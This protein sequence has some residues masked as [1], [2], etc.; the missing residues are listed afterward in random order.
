MPKY[1]GLEKV[2]FLAY[3]VLPA[4]FIPIWQGSGK[5]VREGMRVG[6]KREGE[7]GRRERE[8]ERKDSNSM[9]SKSNHIPTAHLQILSHWVLGLHHGNLGGEHKHSFYN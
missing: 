7:G 5:K 4:L 1:L 8:K 2:L 3:R 9:A 6:R